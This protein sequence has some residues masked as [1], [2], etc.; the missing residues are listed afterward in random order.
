[1]D[2]ATGVSAQGR[3]I[4]F[5]VKYYLILDLALLLIVLGVAIF[6]FRLLNSSVHTQISTYTGAADI[7]AKSPDHGP[8]LVLDFTRAMDAAIVKST[9]IFMGF[10]VT[11]LGAMYVLRAATATFSLEVKSGD[12]TSTLNTSSPGLVMVVLGIVAVGLALYSKTDISIQEGHGQ[13]AGSD[14]SPPSPKI[15]GTAGKSGEKEVLAAT[16]KEEHARENAAV[17]VTAKTGA[18]VVEL[19]PFTKGSADLT[20]QQKE[21][22]QETAFA[23]LKIKG[24][25]VHF[26]DAPDSGIKPEDWQQLEQKRRSAVD[27]YLKQLKPPQENLTDFFNGHVEARQYDRHYMHSGVGAYPKLDVPRPNEGC[28]GDPSH[29]CA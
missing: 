22:L 2:N 13:A 3:D 6:V 10:V 27:A 28:K 29:P 20:P 11:L 15:V 1:M 23:V 14:T 4:K 8:E 26:S 21:L 9:V 24:A 18:V 5:A 17:L 16:A 19:P 12:Q 7:A 25:E